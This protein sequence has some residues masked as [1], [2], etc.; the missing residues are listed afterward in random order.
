MGGLLT[1]P[2]EP[3]GVA[4]ILVDDEGREQHRRRRRRER[5]ADLGP[6]AGRPQEAPSHE[7]RRRAGRPRDPDRGHPR[8][9]PPGPARRCDR[10]SSIL[11]PAPALA[12]PTLDLATILTPNEGELAALRGR[13][14]QSIGPREAAARPG[15]CRSRRAGQPR[16]TRARC[17]WRDAGRGRSH[18]RAS[19]SSTR[20]VPAIRSTARWL[21]VW[22][23]VSIW[24]NRGAAGGHRRVAGG[25]A[26]RRA[27]RD[28][29]SGRARQSPGQGRRT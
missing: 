2:V 9:A 6:G 18:R 20:S 22:P 24:T 17:S 3:T 5:G 29:D 7:R 23:A 28:A 21:P 13:G 10:R 19:R 4:L 27:R 25:G 8:G 11:H 14:G 26:R 15:A 16:C 12:G 1:L